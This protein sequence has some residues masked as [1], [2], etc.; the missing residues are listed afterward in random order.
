VNPLSAVIA[1]EIRRDGPILFSRFMELAL[2]HP[3]YG[4]YR[5]PR[6]PF[7]KS[8]DFYTAEQIQPVFG[9]L[10]AACIR[11]LARCLADPRPVVVEMGAGR[12]EMAEAFSEFTWI[13]VDID[14]GSLPD[15][16]SGVIFSNEFFDAIPV[17]LIVASKGASY[18]RRVG[19]MGSGFAWDDTRPSVERVPDGLA[20]K[21]L[22]QYRLEWLTR[23]AGRLD[24][25]LILTVDYGYTHRELVRFPEGTLMSYHRHVASAGVLA[26]PGQRDITAHVDFTALIAHADTLGLRSDPLR[27]LASTL[28]GAGEDDKFASALAGDEQDQLRYRQQL[29]SL[30]FGMGETFRVL[31][32]WKGL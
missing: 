9:R 25:G 27:S 7:G 4:Y 5:T 11:K 23:L 24:R 3:L 1:E 21:E 28:L 17:D 30:L 31:V 32:Q 2:Y 12:Q 13:P 8:G 14:R 26:D 22:Q 29:K 20:V 6:D 19:L 15:R 18:E 10:M 16:F